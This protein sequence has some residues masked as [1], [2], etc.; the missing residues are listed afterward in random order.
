MSAPPEETLLARLIQRLSQQ[1]HNFSTNYIPGEH[2]RLVQLQL[3]ST[4]LRD[5]SLSLATQPLLVQSFSDPKLVVTLE[6]V[7]A[8]PTPYP[9]RL[10]TAADVR[11]LDSPDDLVG[12][13]EFLPTMP[14]WLWLSLCVSL[15][16]F[17]L[18]TTFSLCIFLRSRRRRHDLPSSRRLPHPMTLSGFPTLPDSSNTRIMDRIK[19]LHYDRSYPA[20]VVN[21]ADSLWRISNTET[22]TTST[23]LEN[24]PTS[25]P[26]P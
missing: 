16:F 7:T 3:D 17:L 12:P 25:R 6:T 10:V 23:S 21:N 14:L 5:S 20:T 8:S 15:F 11:L 19:Q 4:Q 13:S 9:S 22:D 1:Q 18:T 24:L 2:G 26:L